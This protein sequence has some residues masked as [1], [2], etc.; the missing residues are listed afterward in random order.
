[1]SSSEGASPAENP[2]TV[3]T[4]KYLLGVDLGTTSTKAAIFTTTGALVSEGRTTVKLLHPSANCVEQDFDEI[5]QSAAAAVRECF[6]ACT[7]DPAD[8]VAVAFDSQMAGIGA[9]DEDFRPAIPFD[10]WLDMRC[11]PYIE[12]LSQK[13]AKR[14]SQLTGCPP[15]CDHGPKM[16]WRMHECPDQYRNISKWVVPA[17][18]IA[19]KISGL[20][21]DDAFIDYTFLHFTAVANAKQGEWSPELCGILGV[22]LNRLPRIVSP[23]QQIGE[24]QPDAAQQF[25]L[26]PGTLVAAGCGDTAA[27]ALGAGIVQPGLLLDTAGT[28]SV[29]ACS[30][31]SYIADTENL[32]LMTMRSVVPG[33][34]N[35]L[36][37][38]GGGGLAMSWFRDHFTTNGSSGTYNHAFE[39]AAQA[40]PGCDGLFFSPHLGGRI[41]PAAPSMRG[42]WIGFSWEHSQAHFSRSIL[43]SVAFEYR[44]YLGIL[45]SLIP[46]LELTEARVIGGG[47]K[48]AIWNQIKADVLRVPF[49][50]LPNEESATWGAALIAGKAAGLFTDLVEPASASIPQGI[51]FEPTAS[52][53]QAYDEAFARYLG[54]QLGLEKGFQAHG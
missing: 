27:G 22:D 17:S 50:K 38:V 29:L 1:M 45:S 49:R 11:K 12:E 37:Y 35:S 16:M 9:I 41:C 2:L 46:D 8:V 23:W 32:A 48:T 25:G 33:L 26:A 54:W 18:Y 39:L 4:R 31:D 36:A 19:G 47:A 28:A 21:A 13:H 24:V 20:S 30:T 53:R 7:I 10:S 15:T 5:Y 34:W 6:A 3:R 14:I 43:E 44:Y 51:R 40:P 52:A 42:A